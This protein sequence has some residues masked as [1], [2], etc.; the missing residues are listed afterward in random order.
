MNRAEYQKNYRLT[1]KDAIKEQRATH[2]KNNKETI[3]KRNNKNYAENKESIKESQHKYYANNKD[4]FATKNAEY[5]K[6]NREQ[7]LTH[8]KE[9]S[10]KHLLEL[11]IKVL[12]H[13]GNGKCAC[14]RCGF[15]DL[16]AL[17]IDHI[18]GGG[19]KHR[20][21]INLGSGGGLNF[22]KWLINNNYPEGFRTLCWNCQI[23][24]EYEKRDLKRNK[25]T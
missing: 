17:S 1:H 7:I 4:R 6:N 22:Y 13:Y 23:I 20:K 10:T 14:V 3:N 18:Y 21:E 16:R 2:Y 12:T 11:K 5:Y 24:A 25:Q 9:Y 19:N 8:N 15:N